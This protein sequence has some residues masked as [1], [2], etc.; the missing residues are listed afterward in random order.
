MGLV[1]LAI[2]IVLS[3]NVF[4]GFKTGLIQAIGSIV[5][6]I[7]GAWLAGMWYEGLAARLMPMMNNNENAANILGFIIL[8]ILIAKAI[9][10]IAY[11]IDRAF[12]LVAIIP[13]MKLLNRLGGAVV[14]L[15]EGVLFFGLIF[16][17]AEPFAAGTV[18]EAPIANS[19]FV[20]ALMASVGWLTPLLPQIVV[21]LKEQAPNVN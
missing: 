2:L 21:Q 8:F 9:G 19:Q 16:T 14:S 20:G 18:F 17:F 1:D 12:R 3:G 7:L 4:L 6:L 5:G 13:G 10:F 11:L 15:I